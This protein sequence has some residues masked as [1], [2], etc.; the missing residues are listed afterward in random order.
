MVEEAYSNS[1]VRKVLERDGIAKMMW[2]RR[3]RMRDAGVRRVIG[4]DPHH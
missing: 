3:C 2:G 4:T 1:T